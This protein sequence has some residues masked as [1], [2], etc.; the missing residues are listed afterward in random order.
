MAVRDPLRTDRR[1]HTVKALAALEARLGYH[2]K[3]PELL[4][5]ALKHASIAGESNERLEFVGDRVLGL[6][7]AEQLYAQ[8]PDDPEGGLA[9][10]LNA[11]VRREACAAAAQEIGLGQYLVMANSESG[12]GGRTK[13]A[14]LAGACEAVIAAIYFDGGFEA[15]RT[16]VT[17][18]WEQA[19]QGLAP[20]LRDAKT[21]L[22][23]WAQSGA[24][25]SKAQPRYTMVS[26]EGPDHAPM[27]AVQVM[28]PEHEPETG[29]GATKR[30]AEQDA[31]RRMLMRLGVWKNGNS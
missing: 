23:E 12:S 5:R 30:D 11:L 18:H 4:Q 13:A 19:F 9:V 17:A 25:P 22:Q 3:D 28:V 26:R 8:F 10:R 31:A 6:I 29:S 21:S 2:F 14:I 1:V 20:D 27:F 16:F 7:V 15:A 24:L